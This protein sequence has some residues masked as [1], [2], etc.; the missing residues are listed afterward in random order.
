MFIHLNIHNGG[1]M[2]HNA[3][4]GKLLNKILVSLCGIGIALITFTIF[5]QF[6]F[7]DFEKDK[8]RY[9]KYVDIENM[10]ID[11]YNPSIFSDNHPLSN[12]ISGDI[13]EIEPK[14]DIIIKY[15]D[16]T[17]N[18]ENYQN[19]LN[20]YRLIESGMTVKEVLSVIEKA[21]VF[22][23]D[24]R[25][26]MKSILKKSNR[27]ENLSLYELKLLLEFLQSKMIQN[28]NNVYSCFEESPGQKI[29]KYD[30][31]FLLLSNLD[32]LKDTDDYITLRT[33]DIS[34]YRLKVGY[35]ALNLYKPL[36]LRSITIDDI[37][38][39]IDFLESQFDQ[40]S[41][42][43]LGLNIQTVAGNF[44][45][46]TSVANYLYLVILVLLYLVILI[47]SFQ[48]L[49]NNENIFLFKQWDLSK[50]SSKRISIIYYCSYS[51]VLFSFLTFLGI[52]NNYFSLFNSFERNYSN[53]LV[54][55][56][57]IMSDNFLKYYKF[58]E[59]KIDSYLTLILLILYIIT[60]S[61]FLQ[62]LKNERIS[63]I[64]SK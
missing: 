55:L 16:V 29:E 28:I 6:S 35:K 9:Q 3:K 1:L 30:R 44:N 57:G 48:R 63:Y 52:A 36:E 59:S 8:F 27:F 12:Y 54:F 49:R 19:F 38:K 61:F 56:S 50:F 21:K 40:Y 60:A 53:D 5:S 20:D 18:Y 62:R 64:D 23:I 45:L 13:H 39:E 25:K 47:Y 41:K 4:E 33:E 46:P 14:L 37:Y 11:I 31:Y 42:Q 34:D 2:F 17:G 24:Y 32:Y 51:F 22:Y 58:Q 7:D 26:K 10:L 15:L 43:I